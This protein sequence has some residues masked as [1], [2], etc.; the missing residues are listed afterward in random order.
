[1]NSCLPDFLGVFWAPGSLLSES[2]SD[3]VGKGCINLGE[4][5]FI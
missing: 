5:L 3:V 1:M 4:D 2:L